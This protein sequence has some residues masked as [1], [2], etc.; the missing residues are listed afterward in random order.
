MNEDTGVQVT[1]YRDQ[2][3]IPDGKSFTPEVERHL[4]HQNNSNGYLLIDWSYI[5]DRKYNFTY[6]TM[7]QD[8]DDD[9]SQMDQ[10]LVTPWQV[11]SWAEPDTQ[12]FI[13]LGHDFRTIRLAEE[14]ELMVAGD[15]VQFV[16]A[17]DMKILGTAEVISTKRTILKY[18]EDQDIRDFRRVV[19]G[20][21]NTDPI[22]KLL[23]DYYET[24][25]DE[26][27]TVVIMHLRATSSIISDP[28]G[29]VDIISTQSVG[30]V[31]K[32]LKSN[33]PINSI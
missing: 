2:L 8:G 12:I 24:T 30:A 26:R 10:L 19:G 21:G 16:R 18:V 9:M 28:N 33:P 4:V 7:S 15:Q 23:S 32:S 25:L 22:Q 14:Y 20:R 29:A 13:P 6:Y 31:I 17:S 5:A 3:N 11:F 27:T 1:F